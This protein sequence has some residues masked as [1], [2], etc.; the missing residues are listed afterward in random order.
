MTT[1]HDGCWF[2]CCCYLLCAVVVIS[3]LSF[4]KLKERIE[5]Q[6]KE[7]VTENQNFMEENLSEKKQQQQQQQHKQLETEPIFFS[8]SCVSLV[9]WWMVCVCVTFLLI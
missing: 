2:E 5:V 9:T 8:S 4:H 7:Q 3:V 6:E 1:S